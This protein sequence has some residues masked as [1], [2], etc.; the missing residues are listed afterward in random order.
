MLSIHKLVFHLIH[1]LLYDHYICCALNLLGLNIIKVD[2]C[3]LV[4]CTGSMGSHIDAVKNCVKKV[5]DDLVQQFQ[6]C[7]IRFSFVRYTDYDQPESTRTTQ[8]NFTKL[9]LYG[10]LYAYMKYLV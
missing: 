1:Y 7:D 8:I 2:L 5:R 9:V 3:F 4:D 10:V 6:G